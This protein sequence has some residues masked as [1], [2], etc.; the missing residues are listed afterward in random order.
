V[1]L[2]ERFRDVL[3][4][5]SD[6][7]DFKKTKAEERFLLI[8]EY[9]VHFE[10]Q[11]RHRKGESFRKDQVIQQFCAP[12][13]ITPATFQKWLQ[14]Y[15]SG[16]IS[17]LLPRYG[18]RKGHSQYKDAILPILAEIIEPGD[19]VSTVYKKLTPICRQLIIKTPSQKTVGRIMEASGL[20]SIKG[21][22]RKITIVKA[23]FAVDTQKPLTCLQQLS[24]FIR[25][26]DAFSTGVKEAS[27][28]QLGSFLKLVSREKPLRLAE[29]LTSAEVKILTK[30]KAGLHKNHSTK[31]TAILMVN[32]NAA[33]VEVVKTAGRHPATILE[34]IK[35]FNEK[36]VEFIEVKLHHP[37][38][39]K[40]LEQRATRIIDI[41]H[42]PPSA[43]N[44]NRTTWTYEAITKVYLT[45]YSESISKKTVERVVKQSGCSWRRVRKIQTSPDPEYRPKIERLLDTLQGLKDGER[46]FFIDEVGPYRVRRYGGRI[47]AVADDIPTLPEQQKSRGKVQFVA[48]L[49]AVT[50]QLKWIFTAD[51][52]ATSMVGLLESIACDY[53]DSPA[54]FLTWDAI[55]VHSSKTVTDWISS[56]NFSAKQPR[57]EVIPLPSHAQFLNVIESVFGGMKKA[58]ICNSDYETPRDMQQAIAGHFEARNAFYKENPKRA[59]DKIWDKQRFDFD[60]LAGGI[61]KKM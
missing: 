15:K 6:E 31:A 7:A 49:E 53:A 13:N 32:G 23:S 51:K 19:S 45:Q 33:L 24:D 61:F 42:A 37:E 41:I 38:R 1:E 8:K 20:T 55:S 47:L 43:Y 60:K 5:I 21:K 3:S 25:E 40:R 36:R 16:G 29:P 39:D 27:L 10:R 11:E 57:I 22:G 56:H 52:S 4:T 48:S 26:C 54:I 2:R 17:A 34:W 18:N 30:Y 58:V 28:K 9:Q 12:K 50:N 59:G 44:I 46:F 35:Q 14:A